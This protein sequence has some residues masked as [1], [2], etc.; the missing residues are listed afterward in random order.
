MKDIKTDPFKEYIRQ[1]EGDKHEQAYVWN[2]AIG[3]QA[4]DGISPSAYLY[5]TAVKNINGEITLPQ[6]ENLIQSYYKENPSVGEDRT[7]EA[8][9]VSA[10]IAVLL[11]E[12]AFDF[13][14]TQYISI[15]KRL[16]TGVYGHAGKLRDYNITKS[17]WVLDGNTV[18]Y[19]N[20]LN[21]RET[22]EYDFWLERQFSYK[23]LTTKEIIKHISFFISRL[24]QI[25][26]F[27]EGNTRTT[28]VFLIK[29]LRMLGYSATNDVFAENAWYF[30]NAL[31]RANFNNI[32]AGIHETTEYLEKFL[33][34]LLL[35]E[36]NELKNREMHISGFY[37]PEKT[38]HSD[39]KQDV[40]DEKTGHSNKKQDIQ[41]KAIAFGIKGHT[42]KNIEKCFDCLKYKEFFGRE[43]VM[44]VLGLTASPASALISKMLGA[45]IISK[46]T[47][48]GKGK[49]RFN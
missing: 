34:N 30:R 2:T 14:P 36:N 15:H 35:G 28:A 1:T 20:A 47:G 41:A 16:F 24:W 43:D 13:T 17:E 25:H 21:L 7:K 46:T 31:V 40:G 23:G 33:G 37:K 19:G 32:A 44:R 45:L 48:H 39:K 42:L 9:I 18:T 8:D 5:E 49:Y 11:S 4:V 22:L 26:V 3:L 10:R 29:Y 38:G 27:E 6:A 12:N